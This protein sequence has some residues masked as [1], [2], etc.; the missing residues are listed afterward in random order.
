MGLSAMDHTQGLSRTTGNPPPGSTPICPDCG[1]GQPALAPIPIS[2]LNGRSIRRCRQ[3]GT[4]W[5]DNGE[6]PSRVRI[7]AGCELPF[8]AEPQE[9][10]GRCP[11]CLAGAPGVEDDDR[12]LTSATEE[13]VRASLAEA[14]RFVG[15]T[16]ISEYLDRV[17]QEI[18]HGIEGAPLNCRVVLVAE[19]N[20]RT[21]AL[22]SG[23]CCSATEPF[24]RSRTRPS[25]LSCLATSWPTQRRRRRP[26]RL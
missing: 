17:A 2:V 10:V 7:C 4:R 16:R 14:W 12:A 21:L 11:D 23:S 19:S 26:G 1:A 24:K 3:C 22:P 6:G 15:S 8:L 5:T 18:A 13:E 25:W 20:V 9:R